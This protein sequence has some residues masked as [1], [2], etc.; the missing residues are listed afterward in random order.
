MKLHLGSQRQW[1]LKAQA[2]RD[3]RLA[4]TMGRRRASGSARETLTLRIVLM[5]ALI[6]LPTFVVANDREN[7]LK[8][9]L[10]DLVS[11][12]SRWPSSAGTS[13]PSVPGC[14]SCRTSAGPG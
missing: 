6:A 7:L 8:L 13:S 11:L 14:R 3:K 9:V 4:A 1:L 12:T 10:V 2:V 5:A